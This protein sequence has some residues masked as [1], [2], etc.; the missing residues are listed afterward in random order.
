MK[1]STKPY[2]LLESQNNDLIGFVSPIYLRALEFYDI[3]PH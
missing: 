2:E 1:K 3:L